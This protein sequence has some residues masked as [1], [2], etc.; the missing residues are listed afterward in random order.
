MAAL[1]LA[2]I[3]V[4]VGL[5]IAPPSLT[6]EARNRNFERDLGASM[7]SGFARK[8]CN[9]PGG[10]ASLDKLVARVEPD[11]K[12]L[13][14]RVINIG[15]VNAVAMPGGHVFLFRGLLQ[16]AKSPDEIAGVLGHEIGHVRK[17]HVM[18]ALIRQ[19]GISMI[20]S[21]MNG[22]ASDIHTIMATRYSRDAETEADEYSIDAMRAG[23]VDPGGTADFFNRLGADEK[24][25]GHRIAEYLSSHPLSQ[26]RERAFRAARRKGAGYV[27]LL[28]GEEWDTLLDICHND[29][30]VAK[31]DGLF[32]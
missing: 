14:I 27:P 16:E 2:A 30:K 15:L 10:Q 1:G 8:T 29:P 32:S 24:R 5:W 18:E 12:G 17:K 26:K 11:G 7:A 19:T 3:L 21:S 31:D 4:A 22:N 23:R 6:R 9:G 20:F 13:T 28:S 25:L